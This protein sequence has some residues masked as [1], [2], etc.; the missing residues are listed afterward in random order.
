MRRLSCA[1]TRFSFTSPGI[2]ER[3]LHGFFRDFVKDDAANRNLRLQHLREMPADRLAFAIRVGGQQQLGRVLEGDLQVGHLFLLVA[4][5]DVIGRE[6]LIDVDTETSPVLLLDLFGNFSSRLRQIANVSEARL[7]PVFAAE[8]AAERLRLRGRLD[9]DKRFSHLRNGNH[10]Q[11]E[12][13]LTRSSLAHETAAPDAADES[14]QF[15]VGQKRQQAAAHRGRR[16]PPARPDRRHMP[17]PSAAAPD[18]RN[19][20]IRCHLPSPRASL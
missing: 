9:D 4:G 1:R 20:L 2:V 10:L 5:N 14:A 13:T 15:E 8:E 11:N 16:Q 19:S 6:V 7:D 18:P 17:Y 3:L 12:F